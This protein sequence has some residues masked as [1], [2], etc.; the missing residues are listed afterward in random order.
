LGG[1]VVLAVS[2]GLG[3]LVPPP[4]PLKPVAPDERA[5]PAAANEAPVASPP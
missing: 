4:A 2:V 1:V 5:A 3:W